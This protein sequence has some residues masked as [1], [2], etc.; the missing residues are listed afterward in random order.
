MSTASFD[1]AREAGAR[2]SSGSPDD[3]RR[4][5]DWP[6]LDDKADP[7]GVAALLDWVRQMDRKVTL[8][9]SVCTGAA[10]VARAGLLFDLP[11]TTNHGAFSWVA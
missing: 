8:M 1:T 10:V 3:L 9:T 2:R 7:D 4:R 11:A 5:R 6:L